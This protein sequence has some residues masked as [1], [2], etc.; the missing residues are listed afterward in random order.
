MKL[1]RVLIG[2]FPA[3]MLLKLSA[4]PTFTIRE[5]C[6]LTSVEM[7]G[8]DV[9]V[10]PDGVIAIHDC[11]FRN[12]YSLRSVVIPASVTCIRGLAF[13]GC[14]NLAYITFLGAQPQTSSENFRDISVNCVFRIPRNIPYNVNDRWYGFA[15]E[16]Y[17]PGDVPYVVSSVR[18]TINNGE[19]ARVELNGETDITIP[20]F[21]TSIGVD[22]FSSC[23]HELKSVVI[24]DSVE[25]IGANAFADC[26]ELT[27]VVI[28]RGVKH[29]DSNAFCGCESL[30]SVVFLGNEL[31]N[32]GNDVFENV[33]NGCVV[34]VDGFA[35]GLHDDARWNG[36]MVVKVPFLYDSGTH[37]LPTY[38]IEHGE[39]TRVDLNDS[40]V[41]VIPGS[42]TRIRSDAFRDCYGLKVVIMGGAVKE[43]ENGGFWW[44]KSINKRRSCEKLLYIC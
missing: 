22:A 16:R 39:L 19:L 9:A 18:W 28:G 30:R 1:L 24:P 12:C 41:A 5:D 4:T 11:A 36:V 17:D 10:I 32:C 38:T 21:A 25:T 29:I 13:E 37:S 7:H 6:T 35:H 27:S 44:K 8:E 2:L 26:R 33:A 34:Y 23:G 42:V 31:P 20:S 43:I 14:S 15:V 3:L 40:R